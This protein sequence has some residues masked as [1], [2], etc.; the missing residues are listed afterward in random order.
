VS[1][2]TIGRGGAPFPSPYDQVLRAL[3]VQRRVLVALFMREA[4]MRRG[5]AYGLGWL[6]GAVEP[7]LIIGVVGSL[8]SITNHAPAYGSNM[9][10][11]VGTGVFPMY[12]FL[13]TSIRVREPV[14]LA[15][16]GRYPTELPLDE[17]AV[18]AALHL[19]ATMIVAIAFFGGLAL[20]G[21]HDAIP[22][23]V[24]TLI[25]SSSTLF[26]FG[27]GMGIVNAAIA[28]II[29]FWSIAWSALVRILFHFSGLYFVVDYFTPNARWFFEINP[30]THGL[31]WFRHAFYPFYSNA[32]S[33]SHFVLACALAALFFGL[34]TERVLR[35]EFLRGERHQ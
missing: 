6:L 7:L 33:D 3:T 34:T 35:R 27:V 14:A 19:I 1:D 15:H 16:A 8:F 30:L 9:L 28:R 22:S 29:P 26:A 25:A 21:V 12:I 32:A 4:G 24:P 5:Q 17:I 10:L 23:D 2:A 18:H 31:N 11:F 20:L 13:Y